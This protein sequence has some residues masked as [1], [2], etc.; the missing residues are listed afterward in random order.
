MNTCHVLLTSA[1]N[2]IS[3]IKTFNQHVQSHILR[4]T[5]QVFK[6]KVRTQEHPGKII[7]VKFVPEIKKS[8]CRYVVLFGFFHV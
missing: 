6:I 1:F 2:K 8:V 7:C 5:V 3:E 4:E